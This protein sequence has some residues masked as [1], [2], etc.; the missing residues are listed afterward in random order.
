VKAYIDRWTVSFTLTH[1]YTHTHQLLP[2][3]SNLLLLSFSCTHSHALIIPS[4]SPTLRL[5]HTY[6]HMHLHTSIDIELHTRTQKYTSHTHFYIHNTTHYSYY[7]SYYFS[8]YTTRLHPPPTHTPQT[9]P[10]NSSTSYQ[11]EQHR[12]E[13][14]VGWA[15]WAETRQAV[16]AGR[17]DGVHPPVSRAHQADPPAEAR[18]DVCPHRPPRAPQRTLVHVVYASMG[19]HA[20]RQPAEYAP[21]AAGTDAR[22]PFAPLVPCSVCVCVCLCLCSAAPVCTSLLRHRTAAMRPA[23]G[24]AC[25]AVPR[26]WVR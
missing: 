23:T 9:P 19:S 22:T 5:T 20:H 10:I 15:A 17:R 4:H 25:R 11:E 1:T 14:R 8:H 6:T 18:T 2:T 12:E 24:P 3:L 21:P 7:Y 16:A 13:D 26:A